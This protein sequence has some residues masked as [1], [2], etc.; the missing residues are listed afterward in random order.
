MQASPYFF[1]IVPG[2]QIVGRANFQRVTHEIKAV[3]QYVADVAAAVGAVVKSSV[4]AAQ[5]DFTYGAVSQMH[6]ILQAATFANLITALKYIPKNGIPKSCERLYIAAHSP[7]SDISPISKRVPVI[8][9]FSCSKCHN[10][11]QLD[12]AIITGKDKKALRRKGLHC[13]AVAA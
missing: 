9:Y 5:P 7:L 11:V 13:S 3:L 12:H 10:M 1:Q 6:L 4:P 8:R 2:G